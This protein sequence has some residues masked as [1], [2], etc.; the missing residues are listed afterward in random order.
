[1]DVESGPEHANFGLKLGDLGLQRHNEP[2]QLGAFGAA[3]SGHRQWVTH[4]SYYRTEPP[5]IS[6]GWGLHSAK[7]A[8]TLIPCQ[9]EG[10]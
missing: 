9:A 7:W 8:G 2:E 10:V 6:N 3:G 1:M 5:K 4:A